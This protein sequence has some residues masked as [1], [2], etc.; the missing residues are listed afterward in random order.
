VSCS[1]IIT[2]SCI[3]IKNDFFVKYKITR[4]SIFGDIHNYSLKL[5][6]QALETCIS[7]NALDALEQQRI[8]RVYVLP[9]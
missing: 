1:V 8:L 9:S 2:I 5:K 7:L 3:F 6:L 4:F